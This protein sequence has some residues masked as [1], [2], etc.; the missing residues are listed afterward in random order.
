MKKLFIGLFAVLLFFLFGTDTY[1]AV[2][3]GKVLVVRKNVYLFRDG[4]KNDARPQMPLLSKD[5]VETDVR[6]RTKL[7]FSD[8]SILNMG[9]LSRVSVK[10]YL[11]SPEKQRSRSIYRLIDGALKVVV[12]RSDLEVHTPTA[13]AAARGTVFILWI[14]G[15]G[16][17]AKTCAMVLDGGVSFKNIIKDIQKEVTVTKGMTSCA[18]AGGPPEDPYPT[19]P[20][21]SDYYIDFTTVVGKIDKFYGQKVPGKP[22]EPY[23]KGTPA[24]PEGEKEKP[25]KPEKPDKPK[26]EPGSPPGIMVPPTGPPEGETGQINQPPIEQQPV[27]PPP[28]NVNVIFP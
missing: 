18:P 17:S 10:E 24:K 9:E 26:G 13:V 7:Y 19:K 23:G 3:A 20:E 2:D 28:V 15:T 16:S 22:E 14:E 25:E 21:I 6:S 8:D 11:Y 5:T 27:I 12:G 4:Q 1:S